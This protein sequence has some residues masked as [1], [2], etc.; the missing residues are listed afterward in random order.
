MVSAT[1]I[2]EQNSATHVVARD[3]CRIFEQEMDR[4]YL[5]SYLL[6]AD[7]SKAER[8]F[9][10][11]LKDS[12][13]SPGVFREWARSWARRMV[14]QNA[15]QLMDPQ[16]A[17]SNASNRA[18][19]QSKELPETAAVLALPEFE[20]FV[21]VMSVLERYSDQD[22]ALLL[23]ATR[24]EV[25]EARSRALQHIAGAAEAHRTCSGERVPHEV[26]ALAMKVE[27]VPLLATL[28]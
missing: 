28:P 10:G 25:I 14:V 21:F 2:S 11:A 13:H 16:A 15:I 20:R 24:G 17:D 12:V 5:L 9:A 27:S 19:G 1:Q 22:C 26:A 8:C 7:H 6:T 3:F 23:Q 4:L 18:T